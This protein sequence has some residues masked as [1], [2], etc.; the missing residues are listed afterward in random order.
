M[1]EDF[2][3]W[4]PSNEHLTTSELV[5]T[6]GIAVETGITEVRLTGGEPLLRPDIVDIVREINTLPNPPAIS[7][8]TNGIALAKIAQELVDAGLERINVS[9][10]TLNAE[11]FKTITKRDRFHEVMA[12]LAAAKRAGLTPIKIN[13]VLMRGI[14]DDEAPEL[15]AWAIENGYQLRFIEQMPLDAGDAWSR[16]GFVKAE[17]IFQSLSHDYTLTAVAGRGAAPAESFLV[18]GG[19][20]SIG[21]IASISKPFC[22][23]CDRLRLTS[24][25]QIRSCLFSRSESNVRDVLRDVTLDAPARKARIAEIIYATVRAK[26]AG[27]QINDLTFVKPTRPMSA[28]GG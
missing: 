23:A 20:A 14:N 3:K 6:I 19:P 1:P 16:D 5:E 21:I 4:I 22:G 24:D 12:G 11:R 10:D 28:I 18:N 27:H 7:M 2:N 17:E 9:L 8:T 26:E 25:G 13:S 15:V